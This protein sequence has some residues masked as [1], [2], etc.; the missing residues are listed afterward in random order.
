MVGARGV[1][2]AEGA[3]IG[4]R[5]ALSD[6]TAGIADFGGA[7]AGV[8]AAGEDTG[9]A[10]GAGTG[11]AA[12]VGSGTADCTD[13]NR[14]IDEGAEVT[15]AIPGSVAFR[16]AGFATGVGV[17]VA[18]AVAGLEVGVEAAGFAESS[19]DRFCSLKEHVF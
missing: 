9:A 8:G 13:E 6:D 3:G 5:K 12:G 18:V 19:L 17:A 1:E 10:A 15:G 7:G 14:N 4:T 11:A 16:P 2:N